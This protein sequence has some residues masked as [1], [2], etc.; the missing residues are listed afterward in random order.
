MDIT[1][2]EK[3]ATICAVCAPNVDSPAFFEDIEERLKERCEHKI[4]IGDFNLALDVEMDRLNTY[5][6]NNK[7]RD[8]VLDMCEHYHMVDIWRVRNQDC[9]E[10]SWIKKGSYPKKASRI[11]FVLVSNGLDQK[12]EIVQYLSSIYTDHRAIYMVVELISADRGVGYW[13]FNTSLLKNMEFLDTINREIDLTLQSTMELCPL[14]RWEHLKTRIK[15]A[16]KKFA[17]QK[18]AQDKLVISQLSEKVD[19]MEKNLPLTREDDFLLEN[20]KIELEDKVME[21]IQ[22]VMFRSKV[23]W[24]E[25]GEKSTKYFFALEKAKYNAKTCYKM[26]DDHDQEVVCPEEILKL[27]RDFYVKLYQEDDFVNFSLE[28]STNIR[29]PEKVK[30]MQEKQISMLDLELAIK[31]MNNGKTPGEDGIPVDFYKVFWTK[32]RELFYEVVTVTYEQEALHESARKGILNLIPKQNKDSRYTKNLR[33]ITLLNTDYK[34]IEKAIA[35]KMV[36]ALEH[37]IH[38]DQRG[39]M[40][41]RRI[42]V[43]IRKMLDI[44]HQAQ[45]EDLEAVVLS[46][47][48]V[49]CFDKCS[50]Q[51]LFGSLDYFGFGEVVKVWTKILYSNF[52]VRVQNNGHFSDLIRIQKGVHQ[53]GCCS[54]IYFLVIAEILAITLRENEQI[55]GITLQNIRNLLNQFADDMDIFSLAKEESLKAIFRELEAFRLQ[56]GFTVSYDKTTL[57][58][59]GSLRHSNARMYDIDNFVWSNEDIS[60]LG[61]IIAHENIVEKN[62]SCVVEKAKKVLKGWQNRN[63]S[64]IGRVRVINSLVGSLFV[65]KMMVLPRIPIMILKDL[66]NLFRDYLWNGRKAKIQL[67]ILQLDKKEGGLGLVHLGKKEQAL[68]ATWP[69]ILHKEQEYSELVYNTMRCQELGANIWRCNLDPEDVKK[70]KITNNFWKDVLWCWSYFNFYQNVRVE[71][72]II[73]YN[74]RIRIGKGPFLWADCLRKGLMFVYQLF[75]KQCFKS[76]VCLMEQYGLSTL[77][78]NSLKSAIPKEWME[79][80]LVTPLETISPIPPHTYDMCV[81]VYQYGLSQKIYKFILEDVIIMSNKYIKWRLELGESFCE[82]LIDYRDEHINIYR[83]T[84]VPKYR[85]FQYRLLQRALVTNIQLEK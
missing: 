77:R 20:T 48:F 19:D 5:C 64:L 14:T 6:N 36:P 24:Y 22:G 41:N 83:T 70:M 67:G 35:N 3:R 46:L 4:I 12:V 80:F 40:K 82:T 30:E 38:Q 29:V 51:I 27:Q 75:E 18:S 39:F 25:E 61:V 47:D 73:W 33:P 42:S 13:K 8:K 1:E 37:I 56:S 57:Y 34:I 59:I 11:D 69:Q 84:N 65:H 32:I 71:N 21:R 26:L 45:K 28:N 54:A 53:G 66:D 50:F 85:S 72:Q 2:G 49:K 7:A 52:T 15:K 43:N 16:T 58:R 76:E 31:A 81:G 68:K 55:E 44:M 62:Y 79:Y 17:N 74:S 23:K 10:Y 63:L 78:V 60:V 9:R